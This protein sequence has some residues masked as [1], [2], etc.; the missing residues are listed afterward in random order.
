MLLY[1][2]FYNAQIVTPYFL[3]VNMQFICKYLI[4]KKSAVKISLLRPFNLFINL[5]CVAF[6]FFSYFTIPQ[7]H[8]NKILDNTPSS[9]AD[10]IMSQYFLTG[11]HRIALLSVFKDFC[12]SIFI[13]FSNKQCVYYKV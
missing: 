11:V 5:Y 12:R 3:F 13:Y 6:I 8:S 10:I 4:D 1:M 2:L 7:N 9:F